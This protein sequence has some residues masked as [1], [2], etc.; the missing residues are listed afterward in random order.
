MRPVR[1]KMS[2]ETKK[3][4][5][6]KRKFNM[7]MVLIP[8]LIVALLC[9]LTVYDNS[10]IE[11]DEVTFSMPTLPKALE[12]YSILQLSDI[13]EKQFGENA[14]KLEKVLGNT[15]Y[16]IV[17]LTGDLLGRDGD[18]TGLHQAL[19]YF[20][21]QGKPVY[22]ITGENDLPVT[23]VRKDGSFGYSD[24]A[25]DAIDLGALYLDVPVV[26]N[27]GETRLTLMPASSLLLETS[28]A[29]NSLDKR[30][31]DESLSEGEVQS[32][33]YKKSRVEAFTAAVGNAR[34]GDLNIMLSHIPCLS[35]ELQS[36]STTEVFGYA[37]LILSG[38]HLGGQFCL[39]FVGA[40]HLDNELLPRG[41]WFPQGQYEK[42]LHEVNA[43]YQYISTGLGTMYE[44]YPAFRLCNTP[45][46]SRIT[47]TR[48]VS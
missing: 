12:G 42:G 30:L 27:D 38:H 21:A 28:S 22:F 46:I 47:L 35:A 7:M 37:D 14:G 24:W 48:K 26:L 4:F 40:L 33:Q 43:T 3:L 17:V 6:G 13:R 20:Q 23:E 39:P 8:L 31:E 44:K 5:R 1:L 9:G 2:R 32:I 10:R 11:L 18:N 36:A 16:D 15:Q 19:C 29:I 25:Q 45:Q 34:Q 41:G